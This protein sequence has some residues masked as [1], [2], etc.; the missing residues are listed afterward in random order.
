MSCHSLQGGESCLFLQSP[1]GFAQVI[2]QR[3]IG[4]SFRFI[5]LRPHQSEMK[6]FFAEA[7]IRNIGGDVRSTGKVL[8]ISMRAPSN[9]KPAPGIFISD[10]YPPSRG[11]LHVPKHLVIGWYSA[12][13]Q[14]DGQ[15]I[16]ARI[17]SHRIAEVNTSV[18][19]CSPSALSLNVSREY[20]RSFSR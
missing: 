12:P 16:W 6:L 13:F 15:V 8:W 9:V 14:I 11:T 3:K 2:R 4:L 7:A 5:D 1:L 17:H 19:G 18:Y 20:P 10:L